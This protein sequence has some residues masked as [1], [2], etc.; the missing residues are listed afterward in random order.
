MG[1]GDFSS[2][3][4]R[5]EENDGGEAVSLT[6][7]RAGRL[8]RLLTILGHGPRTRKQILR[9]LQIDVRGFYRDIEALRAFGV[10]IE[11]GDD[12]HCALAIEFDEAVS[13]QPFPDPGLNFRDIQQLAKGETPAHRE[14]RR[15]LNSILGNGARPPLPNKLR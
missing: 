9:K 13:R 10:T 4:R 2:G 7:Q 15:R 14:L 12:F 5:D 6:G 8:Y 1:S 3:R 11:S